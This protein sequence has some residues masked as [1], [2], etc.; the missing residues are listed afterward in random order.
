MSFDNIQRYFL[1][2]LKVSKDS[3]KCKTRQSEV[4]RCLVG[5]RECEEGCLLPT[6][7]DQIIFMAASIK[8]VNVLIMATSIKIVNSL[9]P[10]YCWPLPLSEAVKGHFGC[11]EINHNLGPLDKLDPGVQESCKQ[12]AKGEV[13]SSSSPA[14][15]RNTR[16]GIFYEILRDSRMG[17]G[18][19]LH[20]YLG[21]NIFI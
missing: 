3:L 12:R 13:V 17:F 15:L 5:I 7:P 14:K 4:I 21:L 8:I 2:L 6:C 11:S 1:T 20:D 19:I 10:G 16:L 9:H 18:L